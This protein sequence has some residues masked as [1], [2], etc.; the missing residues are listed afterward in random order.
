MNSTKSISPLRSKLKVG[1]VVVAT[2]LLSCYASF[3]LAQSAGSD[4]GA[5]EFLANLSIGAIV[6]AATVLT[7]L[8][9]LILQ[10]GGAFRDSVATGGSPVARGIAEIL[11]SLIIAA[12]L[13]F[14]IIRP[15]FV[16]A[17]FIP[18]ES[19]EYTLLG[20]DAGSALIGETTHTDTVHDHIFVNKLIYRFQKPQRNDIIV[21]KAPKEADGEHSGDAKVENVLIKRLIGLPGDTIEIKDGHVWRNGKELEEFHRDDKN[22]LLPGYS[23][24]IKEPM[25]VGQESRFTFGSPGSPGNSIIPGGAVH[26]GAHQ[27]WV[28]GDNRNNS[29]DS[30]YWGPLDDNRVIGKASVIFW[31]LNRIRVLK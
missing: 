24:S 4:T 5:P 2:L 14:L 30:R 21:F 28:M 17:F 1:G 10:A 27:Y 8:R 3:A 6:M 12:V 22:N 13:V 31:P 11:E 29:N 26:L 25:L 16:Q 23:Y 7:V 20:H 18:S 15:F 9:L 19:M